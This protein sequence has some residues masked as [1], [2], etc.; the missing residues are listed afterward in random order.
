MDTVL[1]DPVTVGISGCGE[2]SHK[3]PVAPPEGFALPGGFCSLKSWVFS[4][5]KLISVSFFSLFFSC[6]FPI[7]PFSKI[8]MKGQFQ[9]WVLLAPHKWSFLQMTYLD[10]FLETLLCW[11]R[12]GRQLCLHHKALVTNVGQCAPSSRVHLSRCSV[13]ILIQCVCGG[14]QEPALFTS[15][16]LVPG[17]PQ[18]IHLEWRFWG[19]PSLSATCYCH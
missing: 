8:P 7:P 2:H 4:S 1:E 17:C 18:T 3:F 5:M 14:A 16:Q 19:S 11:C 6:F 15:S 13:W 12:I 9:D 10:Q